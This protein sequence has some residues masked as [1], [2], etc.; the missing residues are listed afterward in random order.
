MAILQFLQV[1]WHTSRTRACKG[2]LLASSVRQA[3]RS[4]SPPKRLFKSHVAF[5][6]W[7]DQPGN[8]S[9]ARCCVV[10]LTPA[11]L[12]LAADG[13]WRLVWEIEP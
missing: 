13:S 7:C 10:K 5:T 12:H 9:F 6:S 2:Q 11:H 3:L 8:F 1:Y 4:K